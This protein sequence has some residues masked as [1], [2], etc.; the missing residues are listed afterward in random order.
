MFWNKK[1]SIE[2]SVR[3]VLAS[4]AELNGDIHGPGGFQI[5]CK[6]TGSVTAE[7]DSGA[8][9]IGLDGYILGPVKA[10][11]VIIAGHVVGD[12]TAEHLTV[13]GTGSVTGKITA[14][15]IHIEM[16]AKIQGAIQCGQSF[17]DQVSSPAFPKAS[18]QGSASTA[19]ARLEKDKMTHSDDT[20]HKTP[21]VVG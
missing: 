5:D 6:I 7:G 2:I 16:G 18:V 8:V 3:H 4:E 21:S 19:R 17:K 1:P 14:N 9:L 13:K 20:S 12:I 15:S 10:K 11:A